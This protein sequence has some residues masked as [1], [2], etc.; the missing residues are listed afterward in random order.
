MENLTFGPTTSKKGGFIDSYLQFTMNR[1]LPLGISSVMVFKKQLFFTTWNNGFHH[2]N[3]NN[4]ESRVFS[5][6]FNTSR[7]L[8]I[9][10]DENILV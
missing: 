4:G 10:S 1:N 6:N 2:F 3:A 7:S 9:E 8:H 5:E